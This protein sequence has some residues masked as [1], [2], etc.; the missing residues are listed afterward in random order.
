MENFRK[1][2]IQYSQNV[3]NDNYEL[4]EPKYHNGTNYFGA[5]LD[6]ILFRA[7]SKV[8]AIIMFFDY[9]NENSTK[10]FATQA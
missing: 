7:N 10:T 2:L 1:K 6:G 5:E 9:I 4:Y 8:A 3:K